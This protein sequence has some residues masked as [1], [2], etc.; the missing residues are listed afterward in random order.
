MTADD[1]EYMRRAIE[2]GQ[3]GR[4]SAPPNPWVG[5]VIVREGHIVGEGFH[6]FPGEPHAEMRALESAGGLAKGSTVYVTLEPCSHYGRTPPCTKA[7]I[8]AGVARVVIS[9]Q[10]PDMRV[11]G[12]GIE[13][14]IS[15]GI[16]VD[17][18]TEEKRAAESLRAYLH[19]RKT[20]RPYCIVK[21]AIS[22]DGRTAAADQT[23]KWITGQ[24]ARADAHQ[25]RAESQAILIGQRTAFIDQ[26]TLTARTGG[27]LDRQ[28]T[29][30]VLDTH[31]SLY[32]AGPLFD[33]SI[34]PTLVMTSIN[35][36]PAVIMAWQKAG[37]EVEK[38]HLSPG[39]EGLDLREVL[40][41]L[42]RRGV[43]QLLVEGGSKIHG[44]FLTAGLIDRLVLYVGT[45]ILGP[46]GIPL[47]SM[48]GPATINEATRWRNCGV[49]NFGNDVRLE[50]EPE[51]REGR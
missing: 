43:L 42:G 47:F 49:K 39:G 23:S 3:K 31:G 1:E 18:G 26:P 36:D 5:C 46:Q 48:E 45:C 41:V 35:V 38:I 30:V 14:L 6:R 32:P 13:E 28:P 22:L 9:L 34:A 21:S 50:Y 2:L 20:G 16:K 8:Q 12:K 37:V 51:G 17:V 24:E 25:W 7:L 44:G 4:L 15:A 27:N 10:D 19:H 11:S 40:T 29:R 33:T